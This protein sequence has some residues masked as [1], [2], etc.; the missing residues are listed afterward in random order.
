MNEKETQ[1]YVGSIGARLAEA[2][3]RRGKSLQDIEAILR[4]RSQYLEA[5]EKNDFEQIPGEAYAKAFLRSY[6][7]YLDLDSEELINEYVKLRRSAEPHPPFKEPTLTSFP[8]SGRIL[9]LVFAVVLA[10]L[11][12]ILFRPLLFR[13]GGE[14]TSPS[15]EETV[16]QP[17]SQ[18]VE[19]E[20]EEETMPLFEEEPTVPPLVEETKK[21]KITVKVVGSNSWLRVLVDGENEFEGILTQG[22]ER[23]W[24]GTETVTLR[25]GRPSSVEVSK[26]GE[27][28]E[29][30]SASQGI[31]EETFTA[32][33]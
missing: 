27:K 6:A 17:T 25:I 9:L 30:S 23:T 11:A 15:Q 26:N 8:I 14:S 4:I 33:E 21:V 3:R 10:F 24:E 18:P 13:G 29:L 32:S 2:R 16:S 5:L 1:G 22:E 31:F 28:V 7:S 19:T 20:T 12:F